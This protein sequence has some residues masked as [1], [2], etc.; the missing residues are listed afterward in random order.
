[1]KNLLFVLLVSILVLQ[2]CKDA[3]TNKDSDINKVSETNEVSDANEIIKISPQEVNSLVNSGNSFQLVDVRTPEE[4]N[5][6]HLKNS[7]NICVTSADF[8]EKV[9]KLNKEEPVYVYCKS[10]GRSAKAADI[11]KEM[12]FKKV[13]DLEGG[14]T[15]WDEQGLQT[16]E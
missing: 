11:L 6:H 4:Y 9:K 16:I 8:E 15:S 3:E 2:S 1:M 5:V 7:Q 10:G 14:I 12:G 13:Y